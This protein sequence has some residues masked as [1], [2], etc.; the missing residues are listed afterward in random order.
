MPYVYYRS[1]VQYSTSIKLIKCL[2]YQELYK[3]ISIIQNIDNNDVPSFHH[4]IIQNPEYKKRVII[5]KCSST[6]NKKSIDKITNNSDYN[7]KLFESAVGIVQ[8]FRNIITKTDTL[9]S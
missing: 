1:H 8:Q 2:K 4:L 7:N 9:H 5:I 3:I 6:M